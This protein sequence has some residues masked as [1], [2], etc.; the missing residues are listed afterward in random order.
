MFNWFKKDK[1]NAD[2]VFCKNCKYLTKGLDAPC[3]QYMNSFDLY[4]SSTAD[5]CK[6]TIK[7]E[8]NTH[9]NYMTT[10]TR[11]EVRSYVR[12]EWKNRKNK[13]KDFESK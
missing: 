8:V 2:P 7:Y 12:C 9:T 4:G 6:K 10:Y 13:C 3:S 11:R 5:I 1:D